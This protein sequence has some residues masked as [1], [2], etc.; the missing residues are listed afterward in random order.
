VS[1][2]ARGGAPQTITLDSLREVIAALPTPPDFRI[3]PGTVD[4][5]RKLGFPKTVEVFAHERD[6][7]LGL[8]GGVYFKVDPL[9]PPNF[10]TVT[11]DETVSVWDLR[12]T[13]AVCVT[14]IERQP[15]LPI[16][17]ELPWRGRW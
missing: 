12:G 7:M 5:G 10:M 15:E 14:T 11:D 8:R 13:S 17:T 3:G 16:P 4:I 1:D 6:A 2:T 9:L